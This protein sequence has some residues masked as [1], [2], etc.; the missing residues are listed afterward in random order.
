[1]SLAR[2]VALRLLSGLLRMSQIAYQIVF[3]LESAENFKINFG[4]SFPLP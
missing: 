3:Y 2:I 4:T 1:M